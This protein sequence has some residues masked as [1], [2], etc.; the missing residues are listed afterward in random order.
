MDDVKSS[1]EKKPVLDDQEDLA[2]TAEPGTIPADT[3]IQEGDEENE[4]SPGSA[5][6][7]ASRSAKR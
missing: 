2:E 7:R 3:D 5:I 1:E 6:R 4:D